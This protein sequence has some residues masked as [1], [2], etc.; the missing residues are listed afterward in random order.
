M[1]RLSEVQERHRSGAALD[2][3]DEACLKHVIETSDDEFDIQSALY[4]HGMNF[5]K[6]EKIVDRA[7]YF[8]RSAP[9][10]GLTSTCLKVLADFWNMHETYRDELERYLD[11]GC[12]QEWYDEV[13]ISASFF[14][15]N[16]DCQSERGKLK[17]CEL[18]QQARDAGDSDLL[19]LFE[20]YRGKAEQ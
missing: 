16:P 2:Y 8:I 5:P 11:Y 13:T 18:E 12:F 14:L 6:D 7:D 3:N 4:I 1:R 15:R 10:P 19:E 20:V 17:L 9:F